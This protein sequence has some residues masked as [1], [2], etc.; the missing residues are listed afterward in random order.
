MSDF[1]YGKL[2]SEIILK[3]YEGIASDTAE[4]TIDDKDNTIKVDV[5]KTPHKLK[6]IQNN[7]NYIFDG[8]KDLELI[9]SSIDPDDC[10]SKTDFQNT[11][12]SLYSNIDNEAIIRQT[13]DEQLQNDFNNRY[14]ELNNDFTSRI[15]AEQELRENQYNELNNQIQQVSQSISAG[16]EQVRNDLTELVNSTKSSLESEIS[17]VSSNLDNTRT[18]L[19]QSIADNRTEVDAEI[20]TLETNI[21]NKLNKKVATEISISTKTDDSDYVAVK[22]SYINLNTSE[23]SESEQAIRIADETKSGLM[24]SQDVQTLKNLKSRVDN[25]EQKT[26]RL[27][28]TEKENPTAA[29]INTFV[30]GLGYKSPFEGIAVVIQNTNHIWHYYEN[31]GWK[32]D[33]IDVVTTFTNTNAGIILGSTEDGKIYAETSGIGSVNGWSNLKSSVTNNASAIATLQTST[34]GLSSSIAEL[35]TKKANIEDIP[36]VIDISSLT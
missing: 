21:N 3:E 6:V 14:E 34:S 29:E 1:L 30:T 25:L 5:L 2:N 31:G 13:N 8:S 20:S 10:V 24:S 18:T 16:D 33:G 26:T 19:T 11:T 7:R 28:Y 4:T 9:I 12:D 36:E 17:T 32:D 23:T 15:N 35:N 27:L 22:G